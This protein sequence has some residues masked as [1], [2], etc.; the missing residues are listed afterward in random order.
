MLQFIQKQLLIESVKSL[1][2]IA[3]CFLVISTND[4]GLAQIN[5]TGLTGYNYIYSKTYLLKTSSGTDYRESMQYFDGF[6]RINQTIDYKG[7]PAEKDLIQPIEYDNF[8]RETNKYLPYASTAVSGAYRSSWKIEQASFY[9]T[10]LAYG[11]T[12]GNK[13]FATSVFDNSP[14][15]RLMKQGAPGD[16]WKIVST[17]PERQSS[18]HVISY[19]YSSN[20]GYVVYYWTITGTYPN[21]TFTRNTYVTN[22]LFKNVIR[23]E[24][25]N[26]VTEYKDKQ[27]KVILK[28]DALG[29]KTYYVYDELELL[30]CVLPP[31]ASSLVSATSF[32][33][34]STTFKELGYYYEYDA[35]H[36][37]IIKQIPGN[38]GSY[39]MVYDNLDRLIETTDPKATRSYVDYDLFSRPVETGIYE[40]NIKTWKVKTIYDTY[41]SRTDYSIGYP[42]QNVYYSSR[43]T[44]VKGKTTV[45]ITKVINPASGMKTELV[46]IT[47]YDKYGRIIQVQSD[48]HLGGRDIISHYYKY[49][50]SDLIEKT[51]HQ[52]WKT[53]YSGNANQ[54]VEEIFTYDT[55]GRLKTTDHVLNG[56]TLRVSSMAYAEDGKLKTKTIENS[57]QT[58]D[59]RYNIRGWLTQMNNP[60]V[61]SSTK[62]FALQLSYTEGSYNGNITRMEWNNCTGGSL[63]SRYDLHY[64]QLNRMTVALYSEYNNGIFLPASM[65]KYTSV[66]VNYDANGNILCATN[67]GD[68][69]DGTSLTGTIDYLNYAYYNG[70]KSNKLYAVGD[71][72]PDIYGRGDFNE[73]TSDGYATQEYNYDAN[74]NMTFDKNRRTNIAYNFLNL[75]E[76]VHDGLGHD[77]FKY[78]YNAV[79][80][81][82]RQ[83]SFL[84]TATTFDYIGRFVYKNDVLDHI[85][86]P[87]G[88][89]VFT[90][91]TFS[92][93]EFH[94]KDH[95]GN[96][97]TVLKRNGSTVQ[98]LQ[99]NNYYPFGMLMGAP[100]GETYSNKY[101]YNGKENL[102]ATSSTYGVDVSWYDYGA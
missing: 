44:A 80:M 77:I 94:L 48:N 88:R 55:G 90:N 36:R 59:F 79:G 9:T 85:I 96:I 39:T 14:L 6:A 98:I 42:Y 97:R 12:D 53:S 37:M 86:T 23:D 99:V 13:A 25:N 16:A 46:T 40:A 64:D 29:G 56:T 28:T 24:N 15:N 11:S 69:E 89:A 65:D 68:F 49:K 19:Q 32:T 92:Y 71:Y 34:T 67:Y 75:P 4:N 76:Y 50:N 41:V 35:R 66:V 27:G 45:T 83:Q 52:H 2:I 101:R 60:Y 54:T 78:I 7:S 61:Y 62:R 22:S 30:R 70:G 8:G 3:I 93:H 58:I 5:F 87:E 17:A 63:V 51:K 43:E 82:M 21:I 57:F 47:Y 100:L 91:G 26:P 81:K 31:L 20:K 84:G 38:N 18:E 33:I 72:V 74:G 1:K 95:L 102:T 73:S 10:T